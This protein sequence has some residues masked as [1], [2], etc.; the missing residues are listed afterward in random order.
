MIEALKDKHPSKKLVIVLDNLWAHKSSL[1]MRIMQEDRATM[2]LLPS[3]TPQFSPIENLFG[4][5]KGVMKDYTFRRKEET[6]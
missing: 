5:V 6:A 1:I 2:L 3:N 4:Y